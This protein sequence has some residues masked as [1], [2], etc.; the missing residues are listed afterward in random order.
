MKQ[1]KREHH[2]HDEKP[3][4][5]T[6]I[7]IFGYVAQ[8]NNPKHKFETTL[9]NIRKLNHDSYIYTY[10]LPDLELPL[11]ILPGHHVII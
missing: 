2:H 1:H 4:D 8:F 5:L 10:A 7:G 9:T 11:G 6:K 3:A